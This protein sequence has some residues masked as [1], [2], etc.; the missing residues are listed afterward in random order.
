VQ[1]LLKVYE[2]VAWKFARG[3]TGLAA[4]PVD[5]IIGEMGVARLA[6]TYGIVFVV[7]SCYSSYLEM[8]NK[9]RFRVVLRTIVVIVC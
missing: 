3:A 1:C 4:V 5:V 2:I 8:S 9:I 6:S 7:S